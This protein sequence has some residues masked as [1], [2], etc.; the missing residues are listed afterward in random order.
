[1]HHT[2]NGSQSRATIQ[3]NSQIDAF[4]K[5]FTIGTLLDRASIRKRRFASRRS[6]E[7]EVLDYIAYY[8]HARLHSIL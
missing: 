4:F 5:T 2:T 3:I 1:M 8:N 6:A 7:I